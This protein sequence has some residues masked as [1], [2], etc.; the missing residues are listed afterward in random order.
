[1]AA[2]ALEE[3]LAQFPDVFP[4]YGDDDTLLAAGPWD[5]VLRLALELRRDFRNT[6]RIPSEKLAFFAGMVLEHPAANLRSAVDHAYAELA[7]AQG[8]GGDIEGCIA[9]FEEILPWTAAK[10]VADRGFEMASWLK[11]DR[12]S[13]SALRRIGELHRLSRGSGPDA[14]HWKLRYLPLLIWQARD[15]DRLLRRK[16]LRLAADAEQWKNT[17]LVTE[18]AFL[19][20]P[21]RAKGDPAKAGGE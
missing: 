13:S 1:V 7:R 6:V 2:H 15:A 5:Q 21:V 12:M 11:E 3:I 8:A 4:I 16:I 20:A 14:N 18:L 19:A 9:A 10:D 17:G